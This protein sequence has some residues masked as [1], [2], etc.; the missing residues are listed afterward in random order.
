MAYI[1]PNSNVYLMRGVRLDPTYE[2]T[3]YFAS[4]QA[5]SAYFQSKTVRT[6][7]T[8]S[9]QRKNKNTLR[10]QVPYSQVF[11][12]NYMAFLNISFES[13]MFYAFVKKV[14]YINNVTTEIEYELD[15][16]QTWMFN[17]TLGQ[18]FVEREHAASDSIG[19]HL[20]P[21]PINVTDWTYSHFTKAPP[22]DES[23]GIDYMPVIVMAT[24]E[25]LEELVPTLN[26][27]RTKFTGSIV[28]N[29]LWLGGFHSP[30]GLG[31]TPN[32]DLVL[33]EIVRNN[34]INSV[35]SIFMCAGGFIPIWKRGEN[36]FYLS[37][38]HITNPYDWDIPKQNAWS[39]TYNGKSGPRNNKLYTFQYNKLIVTDNDEASAEYPY[40]YFVGSQ[41]N[42]E[43]K[44]YGSVTP[45][46]EFSCVPCNF[47]GSTRAFM[48]Q[49]I[50]HG[51]PQCSWTSD[52]YQ[53][54]LAQNK[55]RLL[56]GFSGSA[57]SGTPALAAAAGTGVPAVGAAVATSGILSKT[58]STVGEMLT[59]DSLPRQLHGSI[60]Q[61]VN[62]Q[63]TAV[64]FG[65]YYAR[66]IDEVLAVADDFFDLYG[67][68]CKKVKIPNRAV[69]DNW[70]YTKTV[71]CAIFPNGSTDVP[72]EDAKK[73]QSIYDAGIRFWVNGDNIGNYS[74]SNLCL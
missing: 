73:I 65:Y 30:T 34:K 28:Y 50:S 31:A 24:T 69:R 53:Q 8:Q 58:L 74:L 27:D 29:G 62:L 22:F 11:D 1:A 72:A 47:K 59:A 39:Y 17:Y 40:E 5:Q 48:H 21:E 36:G 32:I 56:T 64:G 26:F 37:Q 13:K 60:G 23:R 70:T 52:A 7:T 44:I 61:N 2:N 9:Y 18:C 3:I 57:I 25:P 10:I 42:C 43:F 71:G 68:A 4:S 19:E 54:W 66:A 45:N 38:L 6:L 12:V 33:D 46:P 20:L 35:V 67:Y 55:Y 63:S 14:E 16:M 41:T 15:V 49:L 51:Y